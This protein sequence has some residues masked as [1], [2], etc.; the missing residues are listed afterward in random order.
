MGIITIQSEEEVQEELEK[1]SA[2]AMASELGPYAEVPPGQSSKVAL[3]LNDRTHAIWLTVDSAD[4]V[5][6]WSKKDGTTGGPIAALKS[7]ERGDDGKK[8]Y[9]QGYKVTPSAGDIA[10]MVDGKML[11]A[12]DATLGIIGHDGKTLYITLE[13]CDSDSVRILAS[14]P[15]T[16]EVWELMTF[17]QNDDGKLYVERSSG[18]RSSSPIIQTDDNGCIEDYHYENER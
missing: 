17:L 13:R 10:A 14:C 18:I 8:L 1:S 9:L 15:E 5:S 11:I 4:Q 2:G 6:I 12:L 16:E 3:K 7:L